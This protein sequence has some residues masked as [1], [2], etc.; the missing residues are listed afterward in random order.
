M[1]MIWFADTLVSVSV[2]PDAHTTSIRSALAYTIRT[3]LNA[4]SI[5]DVLERA[6][7][8][9]VVQTVTRLPV[10]GDIGD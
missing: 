1:V 6:V 9:I 5:R 10:D 2:R 8:A 3:M 4:G 7:A